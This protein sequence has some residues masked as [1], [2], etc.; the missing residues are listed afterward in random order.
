M[1]LLADRKKCLLLDL[2]LRLQR[3]FPELQLQFGQLLLLLESPPLIQD[4][5]QQ[6]NGR[7]DQEQRNTGYQDDGDFFEMI[8]RHKKA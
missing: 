4:Q 8:I 3:L 6:D 5:E 1:N 7:Q 2:Q